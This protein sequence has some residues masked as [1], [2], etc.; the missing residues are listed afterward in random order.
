[1]AIDTEPG[2]L[3][4]LDRAIQKVEFKLT[5]LPRDE[6][7]VQALL[8]HERADPERRRVY[9]YDTGELALYARDLVLRSRAIRGGAGDSTVKLRPVDL[10]REEAGWRE[11]DGIRIELDVVG[12]RQ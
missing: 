10:S 1:M 9:F 5:V 4:H 7:K 8:A 6:R 11:I 12:S 2:D 3:D